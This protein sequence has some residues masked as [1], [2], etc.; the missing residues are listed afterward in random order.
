MVARKKKDIIFEVEDPLGRRITLTKGAYYGHI[1]KRHPATGL[2]LE[3]IKE[4]IR[5]PNSIIKDKYGTYHY[6]KKLE[7]KIREF[8]HP[9]VIYLWVCVNQGK[10]K[11]LVSTCE[12]VQKEKK[13]RIMWPRK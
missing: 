3:S 6:Y 9:S 10:K 5:N 12:A 13:G 2:F 1:L 11:F 4:T 7:P 8:F